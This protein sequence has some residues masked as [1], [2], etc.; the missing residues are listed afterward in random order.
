MRAN[1]DLVWYPLVNIIIG[2][3]KENFFSSIG[4]YTNE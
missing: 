3:R 1:S 4:Q 2:E